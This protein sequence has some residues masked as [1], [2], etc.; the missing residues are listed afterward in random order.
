MSED[1]SASAALTSLWSRSQSSR[2]ST[3]R[4]LEQA[5]IEP[6][7]DGRELRGIG[8]VDGGGEKLCAERNGTVCI[9]G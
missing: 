7:E 8:Q 1:D 2:S 4:N 9:E 6:V 3:E 5:L